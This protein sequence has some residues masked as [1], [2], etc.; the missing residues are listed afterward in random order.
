MFHLVRG[1]AYHL[2]VLGASCTSVLWPFL[3]TLCLSLIY[4]Y[5]MMMMM[6]VFFTY[7]Y[8]CCFFSLFIHMFLYVYNLLFLFYTKMPWW[9]VFKVFK[10]F[11]KDRLSKSIMQWTLFLQSFSGVC[12]RIRFYYIQQ[13]IM[14]LVIQDFSHTSF[15]CCGF[16]TDCQRGRLLMTYFM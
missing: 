4:I 16:V 11:Q 12:V 5:M 7:L 10:V 1:S 2:V 15:V 6:Y 13:V 8:M 9:V 3:H 14:S